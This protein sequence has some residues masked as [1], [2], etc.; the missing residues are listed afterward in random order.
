PLRTYKWQG[1]QRRQAGR[2]RQSWRPWW[3]SGGI[4]VLAELRSDGF[5]VFSENEVL[6]IEPASRLTDEQRGQV[7]RHKQEILREL[8]AEQRSASEAIAESCRRSPLPEFQA[9]LLL[10]RLQACCNC[11]WFVF[12]V[13]PDDL[14][15]CR[16]FN[17]DAWPFCPFK[18]DGFSV[19]D[20]P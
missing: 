3:R 14:G 6:Y 18:C 4:L 10:G 12:G 13:N 19:S 15:Y 1:R 2:G 20:K 17:D 5:T 16:R 11:A 8:A 9:A 7:R